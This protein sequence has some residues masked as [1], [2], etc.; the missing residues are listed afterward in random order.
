M[1]RKLNVTFLAATALVAVGC[2]DANGPMTVDSEWSGNISRGDHIEIK[3][4]NGD[5]FASAT[6]GDYVI[7]T[8]AKEG[9]DSDPNEVEIEVVTHDEGVTICAM[10]PDVPGEQPNVCAP[11]TGGRVNTQDNDV[12]VTFSV[13]VPAGVGFV[14]YTVNGSVTAMDLE[15]DARAYTVNGSVDISTSQHATAGT[16]NGSI[17]A[18]IGVTDLDYDLSF[19]T[20][21]GDIFVQVPANMNADVQLQTVNGSVTADMQFTIVSPGDIRGA[22]GLGGRSLLMSAVN[23]SLELDTRG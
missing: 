21:N 3:G 16:V 18:R 1:K 5:I 17:D 20:V 9:N 2:G 7:V 14:A 10:Y 4:V 22:L 15:S 19:A 6:S 8:V 11:G 13:A 12:T 23:G